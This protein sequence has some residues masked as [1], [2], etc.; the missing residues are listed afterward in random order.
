M[1]TDESEEVEVFN[2][3]LECQR[4]GFVSWSKA[5][6]EA[7][8]FHLLNRRL[9]LCSIALLLV[10]VTLAGMVACQN[11]RDWQFQ[12]DYRKIHRGD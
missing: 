6:P 4:C 1:M 11:E 5:S 2:Q 8:R 3:L 9:L 7:S 12:Q 10:L